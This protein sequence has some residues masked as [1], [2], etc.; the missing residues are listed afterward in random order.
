MTSGGCLHPL[1]R[2]TLTVREKSRAQSFPD[3]KIEG[4][5]SEQYLSLLIQSNVTYSST[6][7]VRRSS[8]VGNMVPCFLAAAIGREILQ[9]ANGKFDIAEEE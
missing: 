7:F 4:N 1:E 6:I 5:T 9:A 8:Q 2:R 3:F